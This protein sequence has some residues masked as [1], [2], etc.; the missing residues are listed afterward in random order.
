MHWD[1]FKQGNYRTVG[2][3]GGCRVNKVPTCATS[4]MPNNQGLSCSNCQRSTT[5]FLSEFSEMQHFKGYYYC[6]NMM[7]GYLNMKQDFLSVLLPHHLTQLCLI[8]MGLP[9]ND[10]LPR[11]DII[12]D[13]VWQQ[14]YWKTDCLAI[15]LEYETHAACKSGRFNQLSGKHTYRVIHLSRHKYFSLP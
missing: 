4:P 8:Q 10:I 7:V 9:A 13:V 3:D 5:P 14:N 2:I 11:T 1:T 6:I 15:L 12:T